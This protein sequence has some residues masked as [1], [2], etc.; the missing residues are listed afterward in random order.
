MGCVAPGGKKLLENYYMNLPPKSTKNNKD[1]ENILTENGI[2]KQQALF[3]PSSTIGD[4][5]SSERPR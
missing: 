3:L 4:E 1:G 5:R 2:W